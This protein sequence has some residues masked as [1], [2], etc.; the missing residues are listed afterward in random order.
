MLLKIIHKGSVDKG[1]DGK[2]M[3]KT[4]QK[5]E[6]FWELMFYSRYPTRIVIACVSVCDVMCWR[7]QRHRLLSKCWRWRRCLN[8]RQQNDRRK[9]NDIKYGRANDA[10]L[11]RIKRKCVQTTILSNRL[12][13]EPSARLN[14]K[15][16]ESS[17]TSV[18]CV[19]MNIKYEH[20]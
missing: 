12:A 1:D 10:I 13:H 3:E 17:P 19:C 6:M 11:E 14:S 7:H 20:K 18:R 15:E 9:D 2:K 5:N 4:K 16:M 8:L